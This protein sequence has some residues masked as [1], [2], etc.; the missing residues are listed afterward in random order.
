MLSPSEDESL[1]V[2]EGFAKDH[3]NLKIVKL[4]ELTPANVA[5]FK[6]IPLCQ[7]PVVSFMDADDE[8]LTS[9]VEDFCAPFEKDPEADIVVAG[10]SICSK[11][12]HT[13]RYSLSVKRNVK[14]EKALRIFFHDLS[15]RG[16]M[17]NKAYRKELFSHRPL[18]YLSD[19][20]DLFEDEALNLSLFF[21]ARRVITFCKPVYVYHKD[22]ESSL[23]SAKRFERAKKELLF[24]AAG[25]RFLEMMG[26][27]RLLHHFIASIRFRRF[28]LAYDLDFDKK[29]GKGKDYV[30]QVKQEY[31]RIC[32][33]K[34][35]LDEKASYGPALSRVILKD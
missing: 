23:T 13:R 27:E 19:P 15:I 11:K 9:Y 28:W 2:A 5:R 14:G 18:I 4:E 30:Q 17:W 6:A 8:A 34:E 3:E 20:E 22:N 21:Y 12:K 16:F 32:S 24:F 10:F 7:A 29:N 1:A 26:N 33:L 25:R 31:K 35:G